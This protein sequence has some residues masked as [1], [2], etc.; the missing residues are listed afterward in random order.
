MAV[1]LKFTNL[2]DVTARRG[3]FSTSTNPLLDKGRWP[4]QSGNLPRLTCGRLSLAA[5]I[6]R[7]RFVYNL[8][9][10]LWRNGNG[11]ENEYSQSGAGIC[12]EQRESGRP[13]GDYYRYFSW[14]FQAPGVLAVPDV[15]FVAEVSEVTVGILLLAGGSSRRFGADKR[16]A[17][18]ATGLG[19]LETTLGRIQTAGLPLLVC[20]RSD[21]VDLAASLGERGVDC[22]CCPN[23]GRGMGSTLADGISAAPPWTGVLVALADM[24]WVRAETYNH[25]ADMTIPDAICVPIYQQRRGHPVGFGREFFGSLARI[26]G[27][28]GARQ[29]ILDNPDNT[30]EVAVDDPAIH[31]DV[32][33]PEALG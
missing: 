13:G 9:Q 22:H 4:G 7:C 11:V 30:I 10:P 1:R 2:P 12:A 14:A 23:S 8:E 25:V 19:L 29:V 20:L 16:F 26:S 24:A 5:V 27:D 3:C 18:L 33:T 31:R 32:D 17:K 6:G 21:D 28:K 15:L